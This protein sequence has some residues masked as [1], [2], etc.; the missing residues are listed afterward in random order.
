MTCTS[1]QSSSIKN[2]MKALVCLVLIPVLH[3]RFQ[4]LPFVLEAEDGQLDIWKGFAVVL[5]ISLLFEHLC[6]IFSLYAHEGGLFFC[7][8]HN[9]LQ[10]LKCHFPAKPR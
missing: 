7:S 9:L 1:A 8:V 6:L 2:E 5:M 10:K 4:R 3:P